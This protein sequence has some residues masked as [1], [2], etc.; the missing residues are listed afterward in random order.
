MVAARPDVSAPTYRSVDRL[1]AADREPL[2]S[3]DQS[4][5]P[6]PFGDEMDVI[7]L[8]REVNDAK[9]GLVRGRERPLHEREQAR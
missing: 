1:R 8:H 9:R 2:D 3:S 6:V 4:I 7:R 5:H